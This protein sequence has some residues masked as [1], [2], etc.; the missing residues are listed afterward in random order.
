M[1][2]KNL[3]SLCPYLDD[4]FQSFYE[5]LLSDRLFSSV[6]SNDTARIRTLVDRQKESFKQSLFESEDRI[7]DRYTRL[8]KIHYDASIPYTSFAIGVELLYEEFVKNC[9]NVALDYSILGIFRIMKRFMA[10]GY[11]NCMIERDK[12]DIINLL[13]EVKKCKELE[14][15]LIKAQ[16]VW[17]KQIVKAIE[18]EDE[19]LLPDLDTDKSEFFKWLISE[20]SE[21]YIRPENRAYLYDL[22]KRLYADA[23]S[24][25]YFI[26][27][28][29]YTE[30]LST[31]INIHKLL[32]ILNNLLTILTTERT[33]RELVRDPLT[34]LYSRK[35][36]DQ[37]L[38]QK[39]KISRLTDRTFSI[40][41]LD[42]DNFKTINDTYGHL[43]GDCVLRHIGAVVK[44]SIR[45]SDYGFRYGGEE[46]LII[47]DGVDRERAAFVAEK[48]REKIA[49]YNFDCE[50][51]AQKITAS[52]GIADYSPESERSIEQLI[53]TADDKLY[54]AKR[55]GKNK[56]CA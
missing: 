44:E 22:H 21:E 25:F 29:Y 36:L 16:L 26:N 52:F 32:F 10:K 54:E 45:G 14:S 15:D 51:I 33:M 30:V 55:T 20:Y 28:S 39:I 53:K 2:N 18:L 19:E 47:L 17:L 56:V 40:V 9:R 3:Q 27:N 7:K 37:L 34:G 38:K 13:E 24:I 11:L 12:K 50:G 46:L 49:G 48:I 8:G 35:A 6:F 43:A 23:Q 5:R 31:Y 42:I 4:V 1:S 41:L